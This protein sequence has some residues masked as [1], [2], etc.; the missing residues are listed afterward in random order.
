MAEQSNDALPLREQE[1]SIT[2]LSEEQTNLQV[3]EDPT[4]LFL[5][6]LEGHLNLLPAL[7]VPTQP[8]VQQEQPEPS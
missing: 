5:A 2:P 4:D 8:S 6:Q 3:R 7:Y 1:L